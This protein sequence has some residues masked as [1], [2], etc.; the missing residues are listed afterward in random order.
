MSSEYCEYHSRGNNIILEWDHR[1]AQSAM[2][3]YQ[4]YRLILSINTFGLIFIDVI[5]LSDKDFFYF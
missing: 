5:D 2:D 3:R 1:W 4:W